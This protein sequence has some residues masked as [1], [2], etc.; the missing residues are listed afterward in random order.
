MAGSP[1]DGAPGLA[2][3]PPAAGTTTPAVV[4]SPGFTLDSESIVLFLRADARTLERIEAAGNV[5]L[6]LDTRRVTGEALS[7]D[8]GEGRYD[9][10]GEPV[11]V[12]E[13]MEEGC[14]ETT[15]RSVTFFANGE[16][17]S[18]DGRAAERT[19]STSATCQA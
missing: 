3:A 16:S 11:T 7:Y 13:E 19:A 17:I 15:G 10:T 1:P 14:R 5:E 12:V 8:D 18:A 2:A 6:D 9:L 4:S